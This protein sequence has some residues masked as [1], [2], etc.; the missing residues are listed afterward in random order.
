MY[1]LQRVSPHFEIWDTITQ[2]KQAV[3]E[4]SQEWSAEG[5]E[6]D[7]TKEAALN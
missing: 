3:N 1:L 5:L 4:K 7:G 6:I 2:K